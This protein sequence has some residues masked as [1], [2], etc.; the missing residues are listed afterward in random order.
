MTT[1]STEPDAATAATAHVRRLMTEHAI[2]GLSLAV[3]DRDGLLFRGGFGSARLEPATAATAATSY[4]WFSLSKLATA[5]AA[6]RLAE[7]G[8]LDL[9]APFAEVLDQDVP[10]RATVRQLLTHTA[11]L[12]NPMP[13]RWVH[14]A[15]APDRDDELLDRLL[16]RAVRPRHPVGGTARYSNVGYLLLGRVIERAAGMPFREYVG[17]AVLRPAGMHRTG[18]RLPVDGQVATGYVKSPRA[19]A[20][21]LRTFLPTGVVGRRQGRHLALEPFLVD[22]AAYGGLVGPVT[23]AARFARLHLR[24]GEIDGVRVLSESGARGMR[25]IQAPGRPFDHGVGWFRTPGQPAGP[26]YVQHYGAG[27]GFWNALRL[28]PE[29]G[30]GLVVMANTTAPYDVDGLFDAL[31][32]LPWRTA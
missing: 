6:V 30:L 24:D 15:G 8:R 1:T 21:A 16:R 2:P 17:T 11:G 3:T 12:A 20:P 13:V 19:A 27:A 22:G 14:P 9:E 29:L 10:N 32:T 26:T 25:D 23:D 18:Y 4:L 5:T 7:E 28:Y 31:R